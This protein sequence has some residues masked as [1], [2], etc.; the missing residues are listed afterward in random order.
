MVPGSFGCSDHGGIAGTQ[1]TVSFFRCCPPIHD[2]STG[3]IAQRLFEIYGG[4]MKPNQTTPKTIDEYIAGFPKDVQKIL[5]KIRLT[6]KKAAPDATEAI[7]YQI[8]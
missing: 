1:G 8:P 4:T 7:S 3:T 2:V 5:E 6:I